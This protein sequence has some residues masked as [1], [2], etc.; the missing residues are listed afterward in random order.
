MA[1]IRHLAILTD[2]PQKLAEFYIDVF[3]LKITGTGFYGAVWL[4]DGHIDLALIKRDGDRAAG[5]N[6]FGFTLSEA[7]KEG[8]YGKLAQRGI[9]PFNP[10]PNR[11]YVEEAA[12][13]VD[14][15]RFD[16]S[17][18]GLAVNTLKTV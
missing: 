17:T 16:L 8:V 15:N 6:H 9:Q 13:D 10:G 1:E 14:G 4:T 12:R 5:I 2:D 3:G 7:E 11:P 18:S